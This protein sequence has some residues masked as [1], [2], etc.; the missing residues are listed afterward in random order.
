MSGLKLAPNSRSDGPIRMLD[1]WIYQ[2]SKFYK[3]LKRSCWWLR[4]LLRMTES[5]QTVLFL[6]MGYLQPMG[7]KLVQSTL[8]LSL[9]QEKLKLFKSAVVDK[10]K[11][12]SNNLTSKNVV[13]INYTLLLLIFKFYEHKF[14]LPVNTKE[15]FYFTFNLF[16]INVFIF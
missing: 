4:Y 2:S 8:I 5:Q 1:N 16:I 3:L 14:N 13:L 15:G 9:F 12:F 7:K 10:I 11:T 6:S